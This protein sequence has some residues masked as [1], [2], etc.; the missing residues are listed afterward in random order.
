M[1]RRCVWPFRQLFTFTYVVMPFKRETRNRSHRTHTATLSVC[2]CFCVCFVC[3]RFFDPSPPSPRCRFSRISIP[4]NPHPTFPPAHSR[5]NGKA[6]GTEV[7]L[8]SEFDFSSFLRADFLV[9]LKRSEF[10]AKFWTDFLVN[11]ERSEFRAKFW[12]DFLVNLEVNLVCFEER[13]A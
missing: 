11:L 8:R 5:E 13:I 3:C 10:G 6:G 4:P 12:T 9:N 1:T 7:N 2:R